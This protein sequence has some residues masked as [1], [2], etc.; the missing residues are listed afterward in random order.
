MTWSRAFQGTAEEI[1]DTMHDE[2]DDMP[3][4]AQAALE[5]AMTNEGDRELQVS[6]NGHHTDDSLTITIYLS[7][8]GAAEIKTP[9]DNEERASG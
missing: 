8:L 1:T 4:N 9:Q 5:A 6:T 2:A 3:A 7:R